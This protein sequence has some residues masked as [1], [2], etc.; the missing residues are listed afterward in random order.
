MSSDLLA[1]HLQSVALRTEEILHTKKKGSNSNMKSNSKVK[2]S[3]KGSGKQKINFI[4][5]VISLLWK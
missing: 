1:K 2:K 4:G 3:S 5:K